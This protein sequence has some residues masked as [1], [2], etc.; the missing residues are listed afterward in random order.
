VSIRVDRQA[1]TQSRGCLR[2]PRPRRATTP[3]AQSDDHAGAG[4]GTA[5]AVTAP[6]HLAVPVHDL[7]A[8]RAFY[9]ELLGFPEGRSAATWVDYN[10]S[11][12]RRP[13]T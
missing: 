2:V 10:M 6:F 7:S 12:A 11:V 13:P 3:R 9:G 1:R 8:A 5:A 4:A